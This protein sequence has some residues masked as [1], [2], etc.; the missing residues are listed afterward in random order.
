[1][2]TQY[3]RPKVHPDDWKAIQRLAFS[4]QQSTAEAL[5]KA[6]K[7]AEKRT[8]G[9]GATAAQR[10]M[11]L[12]ALSRAVKD[13]IRYEGIMVELRNKLLETSSVGSLLSSANL[14]QVEA[15][16]AELIG[17]NAALRRDMFAAH[18][19]VSAKGKK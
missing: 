19:A 17:V 14:D 5:S 8:R 10:E 13:L 16:L 12:E 18:E 6:I 1:M 11:L 15:C 3:H 4:G 2:G 7:N 9:R